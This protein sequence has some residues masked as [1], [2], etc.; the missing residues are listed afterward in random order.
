M[1]LTLVDKLFKVFKIHV[2]TSRI[3]QCLGEGT[4]S[5]KPN[6]MYGFFVSTV[7]VFHKTLGGGLCLINQNAKGN[8]E[9]RGMLFFRQEHIQREKR[10]EEGQRVYC[11]WTCLEESE[12]RESQDRKRQKER[13]TEEEKTGRNRQRNRKK[14]TE[15]K[16]E[17][18]TERGGQL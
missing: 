16:I 18:K 14:E 3:S 9:T 12:E 4:H 2:V 15:R 6:A 7:V 5:V 8:Q 13:E 10:T 1:T 17:R 11:C